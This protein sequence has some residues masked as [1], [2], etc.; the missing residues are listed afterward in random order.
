[1]VVGG[2]GGRTVHVRGLDVPGG[3]LVYD[4]VV[5]TLVA[6]TGAGTLMHRE[7]DVLLFDEVHGDAV[8]VLGAYDADAMYA[9]DGRD[10]VV[11]R[12]CG[13]GVGAPAAAGV[14]SLIGGCHGSMERSEVAHHPF[15]LF[16]FVGM[17]CL[18]MLAQI[19]QA[20]ELFATMTREW[21]FT[22]VF[23]D[24]SCE[25]LAS[26][27]NHAAFAVASALKGLCRGGAI[28][29]VDTGGRAGK[30]GDVTVCDEGAH[31]CGIWGGLGVW[32]GREG[33]G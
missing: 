31:V 18:R 13:G 25:V 7:R 32:R 29:L 4:I 1:M 16:L 10:R 14:T 9:A 17:D 20:R 27:E 26:A 30:V 23:P 24:M 22:S 6:S 2:T 21:P 5:V 12:V 15:V 19:I 28:T 3:S 33:C 8:S 11:G